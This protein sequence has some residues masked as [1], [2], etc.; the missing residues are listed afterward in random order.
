MIVAF[1]ALAFVFVRRNFTPA[2]FRLPSPPPSSKENEDG[3]GREEK[4][5]GEEEE[6]EAERRGE[7]EGRLILPK[8]NSNS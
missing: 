2:P 8:G 1:R 7:E 4:V 5:E 3:T 6:E